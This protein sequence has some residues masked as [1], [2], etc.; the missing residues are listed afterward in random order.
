MKRSWL[1]TLLKRDFGTGAFIWILGDFKN[2]H[3]TEYILATSILIQFYTS[4][5]CIIPY[6]H[7]DW[8]IKIV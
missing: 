2:T 5:F 3:F 8:K 1:A 4:W 7:E 6:Y